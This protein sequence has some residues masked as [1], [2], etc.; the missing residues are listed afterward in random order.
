MGRLGMRESRS[1]RS[2]LA[3]VIVNAGIFL[4]CFVL[5]AVPGYGQSLTGR[6]VIEGKTLDNGEQN[7]SV[8]ELKQDGNNIT[9]TLK[10]LGYSVDLKGTAT[11]NHFEVFA[12]W[13][14]TRPFLVGDLVNGE[15]HATER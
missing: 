13:S 12:A 10:T 5:L 2:A 8:V 9:G 1:G 7:K 6:W 11:G 3:T 4:F 15:L 14:A